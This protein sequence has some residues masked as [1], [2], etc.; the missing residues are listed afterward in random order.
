MFLGRST[1]AICLLAAPAIWAQKYTRADMVKLAA[2]RYDTAARTLKLS[3]DQERAIKP[4]FQSKYIDVGQ[5]KDV[6]MASDKSDT[7]KKTAKD[8]LRAIQDK[9]NAKI[10]AILTPEQSKE[11]KRLQKD[12]K[13]DYSTPKSYS[14]GSSN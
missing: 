9:Y 6:Y 1:L 10:M 13:E 2:D 11:W 7:S 14:K 3:A 5:V 8:S 12:W 4:L